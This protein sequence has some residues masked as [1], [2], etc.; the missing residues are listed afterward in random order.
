MSNSKSNPLLDAVVEHFG[1][2]IDY[3]YVKGCTVA[4]QGCDV[5]VTAA[6]GLAVQT[7]ADQ[8][9]TFRDLGRFVRMTVGLP[10]DNPKHAN[11]NLPVDLWAE[12]QR[13]SLPRGVLPPVIESFAHERADQMGV[14]PGGIAVAALA[15]AAAAIPDRIK[16][17]V[18]QHDEHWLESAR[19]WFALIG[20]PSSKKTPIIS[21]A[22]RPLRQI[23]SALVRRY[24]DEAAVYMT[25][26][27]KERAK[28]PAP[29]Q[30]RAIIED[31]TVESVQEVLKD[32]QD[33]VLLLRDELAGWFASMER[34]GGT[35][36]GGSDRAFWLESFNGGPTTTNRIGRGVVYIPNLSVCLLGGIQPE[37][38]RAIA[39]DMHDDGL[40]QRILPVVLAG[41]EVG[42]DEPVTVAA[43]DYAGLIERLHAMEMPKAG[44]LDVPLR[45]SEE[46]Q[47]IRMEMEER[48]HMMVQTWETISKKLSAHI[49]K[50]DAFFARLVVT[51]HCIE[52]DSINPAREVSADTARRAASF[53][54]GYLFKHALAFYDMLGLS[55]H[56][57]AVMAVAGY[58]LAHKMDTISVSEARR[59]DRVMRRMD[60]RQ[61]AEVLSQLDAFGWLDP[62]PLQRNETSP[63]YKVRKFVHTL[64]EDRA[65]AEAERRQAVRD[66]IR[67]A[68]TSR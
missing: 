33:G 50:Y 62:L 38:I 20:N 6:G 55:D 35:K 30:Q 53:L 52:S 12:R 14:D 44:L 23:D 66:V 67:E 45:F 31:V 68:A 28:K 25:L 39:A 56:H 64:F 5:Y 51:F 43:D 16:L 27:K 32:S 57:D 40:L 1:G 4:G 7:G 15:V 46:A 41:S 49:G 63:R 17:Q 61:A 29:K 9:H 8:T 26:E 21:N 65:E 36:S 59:G 47:A 60:E 19:L 2:T 10:A 11:D 13:P 54:H 3:P 18:K 22:V 34:Y 48:H 37:P 24:L 42:R 58:I